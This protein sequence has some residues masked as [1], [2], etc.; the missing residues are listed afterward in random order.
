[1][2]RLKWP[3]VLPRPG[4]QRVTR[5]ESLPPIN[6]AHQAPWEC[7]YAKEEQNQCKPGK[8][9]NSDREYCEIL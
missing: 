8:K 3:D 4:N 5:V 7:V 6:N 9:P 1:M 2:E